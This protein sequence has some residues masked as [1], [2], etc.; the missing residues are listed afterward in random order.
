MNGPSF[1]RLRQICLASLDLKAAEDAL[2]HTLNLPPCHR[3]ALDHFGL[4][5]S[6]FALNGTF[7]EIVAPTAA[8]TAVHRFLNRTGGR[9][10]YMAIFDCDDIT[11][12]QQAAN[13]LGIPTAFERRTPTADLLQLNPKATGATMLEFDRHEGGTDLLGRYEWAGGDWHPFVST[14]HTDRLQSI[15]ILTP[16]PAARAGLWSPLF[17]KPA[18]DDGPDRINLMLDHGHITFQKGETDTETERLDRATLTV[19]SIRD[20]LNRAQ[21]ANLPT[22][23]TAFHCGGVTFELTEP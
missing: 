20:T 15:T 4:E 8:D 3:S 13:A 5:N 12:R 9:G 11:P 14:D 2:A 1:V 10:G 23:D 7:I 18:D 16:D 21:E 19:T 17:G 22:E 6:M